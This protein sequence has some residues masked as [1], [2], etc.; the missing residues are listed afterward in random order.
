MVETRGI[1]HPVSGATF[2]YVTFADVASHDD[3]VLL[4]HPRGEALRRYSGSLIWTLF[5]N[6]W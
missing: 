3:D 6:L 4:G 5:K 1:V 2:G